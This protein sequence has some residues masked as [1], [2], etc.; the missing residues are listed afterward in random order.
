RQQRA[1]KV[2]TPLQ[3]YVRHLILEK[4]KDDPDVVERVIKQLRK[5]PWQDPEANVESEVLRASLRLCRSRY[6]LIHLA[7]DVL[8]G[9]ARHHDRVAVKTVDAVLE[10]MHRGIEVRFDTKGRHRARTS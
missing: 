7:A 8:S 1:V 5:L 10:A 2:R 3:L 6:P 9:L 4:L